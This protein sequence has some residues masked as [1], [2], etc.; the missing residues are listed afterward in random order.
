[1]F[2]RP[3]DL[4]DLHDDEQVGKAWDVFIPTKHQKSSL[5]NNASLFESILTSKMTELWLF[6]IFGI[7][8]D[9]V[10]YGMVWYSKA[11]YGLLVLCRSSTIKNFGLLA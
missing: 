6:E 1:M 8:Y 3:S 5:K 9:F 2:P 10:F 7:W 11:W 4:V